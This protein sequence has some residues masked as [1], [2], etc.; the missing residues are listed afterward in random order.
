MFDGP[1]E[2]PNSSKSPKL[3]D[4]RAGAASAGFR[5]GTILA[6]PESS[7]EVKPRAEAFDGQLLTPGQL[8]NLTA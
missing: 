8:E 7:L 1:D 3:P 2:L 6:R 4:F 5:H